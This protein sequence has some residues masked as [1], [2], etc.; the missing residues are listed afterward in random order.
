MIKNDECYAPLMGE[1]LSMSI[2]LNPLGMRTASEQIFTTLLPGMNV[3]TLRIR[4]YSFYCWL[5]QRFYA[6]RHRAALSD[7]RKYIR[8]SELLLALI[9]VACGR[10]NGVPG[11][12]RAGSILLANKEE[13][14]FLQDAIPDDKDTKSY[15]DGPNGILG[16]Y[17]VVAL[18]ELNLIKPLADD[19][20]MYN[21]TPHDETKISGEKMAEAFGKS[22][23]KVSDLF[24]SCARSGRVSRA[25]LLEM[26]PYFQTHEMGNSEERDLLLQ[27]LLQTDRTNA[28]SP[29]HFRRGTMRLLL[30]FLSDRQPERFSEIDFAAYV[31][32]QFAQGLDHSIVAMG[33][34]AY[35][36]NDRRQYAS[37]C[38]FNELLTILTQSDAPGQWESIATL[39][40]QLGKDVVS[41]LDCDSL[42]VAEALQRW[43]I[44]SPPDQKMALAFYNLLDDYRQNEGFRDTQKR[45][46]E[47]GI[48]VTND[49]LAAFADLEQYREVPLTQYIQRFLT[50]KIIY[51][52]YAEAMRKYCLTGV[53]THKLTIESGRVK[54]L[55]TYEPSHSTPRVGTL[56]EFATDLA[57]VKEA[58]LTPLG[59]E[60]LKL[61]ED[62]N[63]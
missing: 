18:Q 2:G 61:L 5:L 44:I 35:H 22:V 47:A 33:W 42:T 19:P 59:M 48:A 27:V 56:Y 36:L 10:A 37:L 49:A 14:D 54:G 9:H 57:L 58:K 52:H 43:P 39:T 17:Y 8:T 32:E 30:R 1:P 51:N 46:K 60:T 6:T 24:E 26:A 53:A 23:E 63:A 12:Q 31:Y 3:V 11:T 21:I 4:Y 38:I 15:W 55:A 62:D 45:I 25:E 50:E 7:F 34:Y 13:I 16:S 29:T 40:A 20:R 28:N 41:T